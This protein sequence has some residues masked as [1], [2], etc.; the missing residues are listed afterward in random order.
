MSENHESEIAE[1][2]AFLA[3]RLE[4]EIGGQPNSPYR[5]AFNDGNIGTLIESFIHIGEGLFA[6]AKAID[7]IDYRR[8]IL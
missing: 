4:A 1:A 2:I 6:I 8:R 3:E 5:S 7:S